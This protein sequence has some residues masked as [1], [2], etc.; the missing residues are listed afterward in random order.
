MPQD[1]YKLNDLARAKLEDLRRCGF[2]PTDD[3]VVEINAL[4]EDVLTPDTRR[5]LARGRPVECGG[6]WFCPLT[7]SSSAWFSCRFCL[8]KFLRMI[9]SA[10]ISF[11]HRASTDRKHGFI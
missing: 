8:R 7:I 1:R 5:A 9:R 6:A 10:P 11:P 2:A 4:A 3:D